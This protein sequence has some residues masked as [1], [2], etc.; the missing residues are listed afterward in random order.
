MV[1]ALLIVS[2]LVLFFAGVIVGAC[3]L[4]LLERDAPPEPEDKPP[5]LK[6]P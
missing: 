3:L 1:C 6:H 5:V 2:G 4:L